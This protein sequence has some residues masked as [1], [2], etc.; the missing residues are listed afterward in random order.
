M[1]LHELISWVG[2]LSGARLLLA[3]CVSG[4]VS[5]SAGTNPPCPS[6]NILSRLHGESVPLRFSEQ[7]W[8]RAPAERLD[9]IAASLMAD[10]EPFAFEINFNPWYVPSMQQPPDFTLDGLFASPCY[11]TLYM[12]L[13]WG[14]GDRTNVYAGA[15]PF[16][17]R[18]GYLEDSQFFYEPPQPEPPE[19]HMRV[20][21]WAIDF[22]QV[23]RLLETHA[24]LFSAGLESIEVTTAGRYRYKET[25]QPWGAAGSLFFFRKPD[26]VRKTL[27][28]IEPSRPVMELL[29]ATRPTRKKPCIDG[30]EGHYLIAD[31]STGQVLES[32]SFM[33]CE[34]VGMQSCKDDRDCP[35][36]SRCVN[37]SF[38]G[39]TNVWCNL[40][41]ECKYSEFCDY[42]Q[43]DR[44]LFRGKCAPRGGHYPDENQ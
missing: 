7:P 43:P 40:D 15:R 3:L 38:C 30:S 41:A 19:Q 42:S 25:S 9:K 28:G 34:E 11:Q 44:N 1:S 2:K 6:A 27:D 21:G 32:G 29:E 35:G 33:R 10:A 23:N 13:E 26:G 14:Y 8:L 36:S 37:G 24:D 4:A 39:R 12:V 22:P 20:H 18:A 17:Q 5:A 31:G 16:R